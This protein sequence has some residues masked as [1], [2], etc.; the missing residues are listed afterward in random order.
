MEHSSDRLTGLSRHYF[1]ERHL[2]SSM[3][4]S[5]VLGLIP[6][7][8]A[9]ALHARTA[10]LRL[11]DEE[12]QWLE[13]VFASDG[14]TPDE[15]RAYVRERGLGAFP[16]VISQEL[17]IA[18]GVGKLPYAALL[19]ARGVLVAKGIV[20]TREHLESLLEAHRLG[21]ADI[22]RYLSARA[23]DAAASPATTA[24]Y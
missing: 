21:V 18:F 13:V 16:Y 9:G 23:V 2:G 4:L 22:N 19:D 3:E 8:S 15:H 5:Q 10:V 24:P 20:N 14:S 6:R 11:A 17:G 7:L 12:R 1:T